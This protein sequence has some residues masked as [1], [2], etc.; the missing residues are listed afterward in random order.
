[1]R[2]I[3]GLITGVVVGAIAATIS[4]SQSGQDIRAEFDR[5][6]VDLEKRDFEAVGSRLEQRVADLQA[7]IEERFAEAEEAGKV[8]E[9]AAEDAVEAAEETEEAEEAEPVTA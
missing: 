2:F 7:S 6:R 1:M 8:A 5:I 4:Q 3:I 9:D